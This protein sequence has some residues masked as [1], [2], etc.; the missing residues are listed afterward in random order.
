MIKMKFEPTDTVDDVY[1]KVREHV[2]EIKNGTS[3]NSTEKVAKFLFKLPRLLLRFVL[4]AIKLID[5]YG[6]LPKKLLDASPF[7]GSLVIT[8]LGSLGIRPVF[9]HI[10]NLGN[11]PA[12]LAFGAKRKE[13]SVGKDGKHV[14]RKNID[15]NIALDERI[16]DGHYFAVALK[17]FKVCLRNPEMLDKPP[18]TVIED[19][20]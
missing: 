4:G 6:K 2:E 13:Y 19:V 20:D 7:H 16:C 11:I 12:F 10:Y 5:Y 18:E 14:E 9:H 3:D 1:N 15:Y 8:D 17:M